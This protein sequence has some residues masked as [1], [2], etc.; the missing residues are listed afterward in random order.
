M[1]YQYQVFFML[2]KDKCVQ[3]EKRSSTF[4]LIR[5]RITVL[6]KKDSEK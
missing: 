5:L 4:F 6:W 3:N 1:Y 2:N